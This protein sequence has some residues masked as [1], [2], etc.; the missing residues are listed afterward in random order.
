MKHSKPLSIG[1]VYRYFGRN[2]LAVTEKLLLVG[3]QGKLQIRR[4][5]N[6]LALTGRDVEVGELA[7]QWGVKVSEIDTAT[8]QYF[9]PS[10]EGRL[11][12]ER[13]LIDVDVE[14]AECLTYP[15]SSPDLRASSQRLLA[16]LEM[17]RKFERWSR[18][19]QTMPP[20]RFTSD[21]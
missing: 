8:R 19:E 21:S 1:A 13:P 3:H 2:A 12:D 18:W 6:V 7:R 20:R 10:S 16:Q 15:F 9:V 11:P 5:R 14:Q 4:P 17:L